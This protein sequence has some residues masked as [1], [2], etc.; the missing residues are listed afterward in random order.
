[1][2][3]VA[4]RLGARVLRSSHLAES[5]TLYRALAGTRNEFGEWDDGGFASSP[6][7]LVTAP[8][9]G[10]ERDLLP[11]GIRE[12]ELRKF[13]LTETVTAAADLIPGDVVRHAS[14]DY[15]VERSDNWRGFFAVVASFPFVGDLT[16]VVVTEDRFL[17]GTDRFLWGADRMVWE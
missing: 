6:I 2:S 17:W 13:F 5:G 4:A 1:M 8:V 14:R 12:K 10:Q 16:P 7:T 15:R 11:E 9:S 3:A